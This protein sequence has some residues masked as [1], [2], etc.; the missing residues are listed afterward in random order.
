MRSY[1]QFCPVARALDVIGERWAL[2]VV[3][4]LL[5]RPCRFTDLRDG[6]PGI[7]S[8]LLADRLRSLEQAGVVE[9]AELPP[10]AASTVYRVTDRGRGLVP[11]IVELA[12]WGA[13][14]LE[15]GRGDDHFFGRWMTL[16]EVAVFRGVSTADVAP[17]VVELRVDGEEA[18]LDVRADGVGL[19][20]D[21]TGPA[22]VVFV[23]DA[24][25]AAR[26]LMR[27]LEVDDAVELGMAEVIGGPDAVERLR[28]LIGRVE[29]FR[30]V[31]A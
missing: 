31:P 17:L 28:R 26:V 7:A 6:L 20:L 4:E 5:I 14:L 18:R 23:A 11:V 16:L 30:S 27:D 15:S 29:G 9:R 10:P 1:A 13:P 19:L 2:L 21:T 24:S 25:T 8:N 3:R 12:V 22:D